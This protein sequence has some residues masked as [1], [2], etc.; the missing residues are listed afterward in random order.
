M[1]VVYTKIHTASEKHGWNLH[2][3]THCSLLA[4]NVFITEVF[5]KLQRESQSGEKKMC[6][7]I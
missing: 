7:Y 5:G 6:D 4:F 3:D 1:L 2:Q